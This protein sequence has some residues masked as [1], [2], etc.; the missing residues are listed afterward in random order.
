MNEFFRLN[1]S[2]EDNDEKIDVTSNASSTSSIIVA[3][4]TAAKVTE[5]TTMSKPTLSI[6]V[7][8]SANATQA[9]AAS[10]N[11]DEKYELNISCVIIDYVRSNNIF[12]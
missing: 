4:I 9:A 10:G 12:L 5:T 7:S 8:S 11:M 1:S 6:T 3:S 2:I